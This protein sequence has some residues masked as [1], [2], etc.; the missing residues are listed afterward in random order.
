MRIH[1]DE[2]PMDCL[3]DNEYMEKI[4]SE[5]SDYINPYAICDDIDFNRLM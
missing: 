1:Y 2:N 4:E 3:D 5:V